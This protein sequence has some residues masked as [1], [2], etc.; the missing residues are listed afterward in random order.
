MFKFDEQVYT[1]CFL[2]SIY[3]SKLRTVAEQWSTMADRR[4]NPVT[5]LFCLVL[6]LCSAVLIILLNKTLYTLYGCPNIT[7]TFIHFLMTSAG[8]I[9]CERLNVFQVKILPFRS[10]LPLALTFCG[11]VVLTNLSLQSNTVGTYQLIK[12]MT[13][14][15]IIA[16]QSIAYSR[17]FS[18]QVK[19][20]VVSSCVNGT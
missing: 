6:N 13:T 20:T 2:C 1:L 9:I 14:P 19:C 8:L 12:T 5:V 17:R 10:M 11:F 3:L 16:I 18:F 15:C 4:T 7:L